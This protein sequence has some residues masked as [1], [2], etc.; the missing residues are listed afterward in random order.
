MSDEYSDP[1]GNT[2]Q[3]QAFVHRVEEEPAPAKRTPVGLLIG[4]AAVIIVVAAVAAYLVL[5]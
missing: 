4:V 2:A 3:F 5:S 1:S